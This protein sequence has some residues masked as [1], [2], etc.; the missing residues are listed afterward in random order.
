MKDFAAR[1]TIWGYTNAF[2]VADYSPASAALFWLVGAT[3]ARL[4][5]IGHA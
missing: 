2:E 5:R 4:G 1:V 3:A